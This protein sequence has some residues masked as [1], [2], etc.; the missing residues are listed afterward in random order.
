LTARGCGVLSAELFAKLDALASHG[1][2]VCLQE[3]PRAAAE[4]ICVGMAHEM[5][6]ANDQLTT[7]IW[8]FARA[9]P[10]ALGELTAEVQEIGGEFALVVSSAG[11]GPLGF[12]VRGLRQFVNPRH[13]VPSGEGFERLVFFPMSVSRILRRAGVDL[14]FVSSWAKE[15][16]FHPERRRDEPYGEDFKRRD[17]WAT[18]PANVRLFCELLANHK[19]PLLS[20]HD[21]V[22]HL[23]GFTGSLWPHLEEVARSLGRCLDGYF[24]RLGRPGIAPLILPFM[25]GY[26]AD[27]YAQP[28]LQRY[29]RQIRVLIETLVSYLDTHGEALA[30]AG[31]DEI[32][33]FPVQYADFMSLM[34]SGEDSGWIRQRAWGLL[35]VIAAPPS[36]SRAR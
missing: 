10:F 19:L 23:A 35:D 9:R 4:L 29:A 17:Y 13:S 7:A 22:Y 2:V 31:A 25:A 30:E 33:E 36:A 20:S 27:N 8:D 24:S 16:V 28:L 1:D 21:L 15:T 5:G 14:V 26:L 12:A 6:S 32:Q 34:V 18:F 3:Q 11:S